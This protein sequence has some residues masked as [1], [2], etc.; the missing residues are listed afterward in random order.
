MKPTCPS[1]K[2]SMIAAPAAITAVKAA[3]LAGILTA[4]APAV[5]LGQSIEKKG[6]APYVTH[7]IFRPLTGID[8]A[9]IGKATTL[10]AVGSTNDIRGAKNRDN[11]SAECADVN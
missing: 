11:V 4:F 3:L 9:D 7:F 10:A 8:L 1:M 5:V 2:L 6:T